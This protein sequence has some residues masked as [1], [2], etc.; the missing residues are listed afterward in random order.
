MSRSRIQLYRY[1]MKQENG[2]GDVRT[3]NVFY[4]FNWAKKTKY[5][6]Y[7]EVN[8]SFCAKSNETILRKHY[9][10]APWEREEGLYA[11]RDEI[12]IPQEV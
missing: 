6:S 8:L 3:P 7:L 2:L 11:Y 1:R 12:I 10:R 4:E 9:S 5:P